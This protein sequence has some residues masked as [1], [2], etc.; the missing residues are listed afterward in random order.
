M[1]TKVGGGQP[2]LACL[3]V[4][5]LGLGS[6]SPLSAQQPKLLATL[7]GHTTGVE[8]VTFSP[9]GKTLASAGD[10]TIKLWDVASGK[11]IAM[12]NRH[13]GVLSLAFGPDGKTLA[14]GSGG[15]N[16][17]KRWG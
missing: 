7:N 12:L 9:D 11:N 6:L 5:C 8:S 13:K 10:N 4:V 17:I 15:D 2:G 16:T 3:A 1:K 14:S